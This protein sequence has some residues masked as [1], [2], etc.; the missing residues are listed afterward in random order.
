M[1]PIKAVS[2]RCRPW[3][4]EM[5]AFGAGHPGC[6]GH[7]ALLLSLLGLPWFLSFLRPD[8]FS[9]GVCRLLII[10]LAPQPFATAG[11]TPGFLSFSI[12]LLK[13][14]PQAMRQFWVIQKP[15]HQDLQGASR[16]PWSV[17]VRPSVMLCS[18]RGGQHGSSEMT[19]QHDE[20]NP[21]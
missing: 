7:S 16:L 5:S 10:F 11:K 17:C 3:E 19:I 20:P 9:L 2:Q 18:P 15:I 21:C 13:R 8:S 12:S 1:W 14:L 4:A 6:P